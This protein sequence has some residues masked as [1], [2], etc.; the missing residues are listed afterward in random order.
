MCCTHQHRVVFCW[1]LICT[2][3]SVCTGQGKQDG[4][5]VYIE[6]R[7]PPGR[8]ARFLHS[9]LSTVPF[10]ST[11]CFLLE[12]TTFLIM[13]NLPRIGKNYNASKAALAKSEFLYEISRPPARSMLGLL[14]RY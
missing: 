5:G 2:H 13:L 7:N 11:E 8:R 1:Y 3:A 14:C 12:P 4:R 9:P 6:I 10:K